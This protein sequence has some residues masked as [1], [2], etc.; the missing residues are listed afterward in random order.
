MMVEAGAK[1]LPESVM[2]D[3]IAY[4]QAELQQSIDLQE[5][6]VATAGKPKKLPF[7]GPK[8][9]SVVKLGKALAEGETE[10]VVFDLETTDEAGERLHRRHRR[11]EGARRR[12]RRPLRVARQP[13]P[14]DRRPPGPRHLR[15]GRGRRADRGRGPDPLREW[16]ATRRWWRTTSPSTSRSSC[17]T[18]R[19]TWLGAERGLRHAR[20]GLS[21]LPDAGA[22]KLADLVRFVFGRD[23]AAAHR[24]MPDAEATAELF[25]NLTEA[26][27]S[28]STPSARTSPTR[29]GARA[30]ATTAA[31]RAI[32]WRTSAA[33]T[34]SVRADGRPHQGDRPRAGPVENIRIDGRDTTTIRP[35]SVEVGIL[36]R[37]H[38]S[39][40]F[41]RGQ[42]Q[43][44]SIATLGPSSDVQRWTRSPGD[45][46]ALPAPL[47]LPAVLGGRGRPMRGP[48]RREIG[49]G[50]L[51]E[52]AHAGPA[53][54]GRVPY[55]IRVVARWSAATARPAWR[56]PAA[57]PWR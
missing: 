30:R 28:G 3:A 27:P 25:I 52:R 13:R 12:G 21:A 47:Q 2:A 8:A 23:H 9:D 4:G 20:A 49:H 17:A 11:P 48:G 35:I 5:K 22:Y 10:F 7:L 57:A 46:E 18:C 19:T 55:V 24:A 51:A 40:I 38:G 15:R 53:E 26:W 33:A 41:T 56:A 50:A 54:R 39:G 16:V 29:S 31:S 32:G 6:L 36:P 45:R 14:L 37:T 42:T 43:A 34:A 1:I 44:L